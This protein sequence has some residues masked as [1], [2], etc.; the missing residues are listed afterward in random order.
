MTELERC[1][2]EIREVEQLL[3]SSH[4]DAEGLLLSPIGAGGAA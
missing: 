1:E 2:Q 3:R 4:P